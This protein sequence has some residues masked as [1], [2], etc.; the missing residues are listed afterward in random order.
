MSPQYRTMNARWIGSRIWLWFSNE[1]SERE[2][3]KGVSQTIGL[4]HTDIEILATA[5]GAGS[6]YPIAYCQMLTVYE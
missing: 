2:T 3:R 6:L 4:A 5:R 1:R